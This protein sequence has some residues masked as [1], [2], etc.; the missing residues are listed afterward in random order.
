VLVGGEP[1]LL[2]V[3]PL[4]AELVVVLGADAPMATVPLLAAVEEVDVR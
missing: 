4:L 2:V 1:A 3:W